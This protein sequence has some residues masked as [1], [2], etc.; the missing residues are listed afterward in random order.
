VLAA[1]AS[2]CT[3]R[4]FVAAENL[5]ALDPDD[6]ALAQPLEQLLAELVDQRDTGLDEHL[7]A[8]VRVTTGDRRLGVEHG[9]DADGH[10]RV[11]GDPVDVD[12]VDHGDVAGPQPPD[13]PLGAPVKTDGAGDLTRF[14]LPGTA[15]QW[16]T[17]REL[18]W[19]A[20][21]TSRLHDM[22]NPHISGDL[23]HGSSRSRRS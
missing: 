1:N 21:A 16:K 15:Q 4:R 13:Q 18:S 14:G 9:G 11:G 17:H 12:V 2:N 23:S 10:Q 6:V 19:H 5:V 8:E 3:D 22:H 7:G 20:A